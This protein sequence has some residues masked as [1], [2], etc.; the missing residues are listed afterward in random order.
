MGYHTRMKFASVLR[1]DTPSAVVEVLLAVAAGDWAKAEAIAPSHEFFKAKR[2]I[3][4]LRGT[5]DAPRWPE[6]DGILVIE[7]NA[8]DSFKFAFHSSTK[9]Y[10]SEIDKFLAWIGPYVASAPGEVLGEFEG[11]ED[12]RPTL[13]VAQAGRIDKLYVPNEVE[14]GSRMGLY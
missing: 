11:E 3:V 1:N 5:Y 9:N 6:A 14:S 7:G 4:L 13:L 12:D 8:D 2:W 10:D